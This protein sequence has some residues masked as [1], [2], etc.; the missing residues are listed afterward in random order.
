MTVLL[1]LR[2]DFRNPAFAGTTTADRF[3]AAIEMAEWA[4]RLGCGSSVVSDD[5]ASP[6]VVVGA[7]DVHGGFAMFG[8]PIVVRSDDRALACAT[9]VVHSSACRGPARLQ[10]THRNDP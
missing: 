10:V 8:V 7:A 9:E 4:D 2:F 6:D 3:E 5:H 1:A